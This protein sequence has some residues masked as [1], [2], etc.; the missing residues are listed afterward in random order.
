MNPTDPNSMQQ[1]PSATAEEVQEAIAREQQHQLAFLHNRVMELSIA[2]G[3]LET[4]NAQLEAEVQH[5]R[6]AVQ[7]LTPHPAAPAAE[8]VEAVWTDGDPDHEEG[9]L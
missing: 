7:A 2:A 5:L 8:P 1:P 4:R 6:D 9:G 3:R